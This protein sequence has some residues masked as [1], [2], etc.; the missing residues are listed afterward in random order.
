[1]SASVNAGLTCSAR[2]PTPLTPT[3]VG[4]TRPAGGSSGA[5]VGCATAPSPLGTEIVGS[6]L[7]VSGL[8]G[9]PSISLSDSSA[10]ASLNASACDLPSARY[11]STI[12]AYSGLKVAALA[13]TAACLRSLSNFSCSK[14]SARWSRAVCPTLAVVI[15]PAP[16]PPPSSPSTALASAIRLKFFLEMRSSS[17]SPSFFSPRICK[18]SCPAPVAASAPII[19]GASL[20]PAFT[21][22]RFVKYLIP[23]LPARCLRIAPTTPVK[24]SAPEAK[25]TASVVSL[26]SLMYCSILSACSSGGRSFTLSV[27]NCKRFPTVSPTAMPAPRVKAPAPPVVTAAAMIGAS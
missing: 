7:P 2:V 1:M 24:S 11:L 22:S 26:V 18:V 10:P 23:S 13:A 12:P 9:P 19:L 20:A 4:S 5:T 16:T 21:A 15:T 25:P 17:I 8:V 6:T 27:I 3:P 14:R